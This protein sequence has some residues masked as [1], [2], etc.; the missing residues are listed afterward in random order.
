MQNMDMIGVDVPIESCSIERRKR[1][2]GCGGLHQRY[3][4]SNHFIRK[5]LSF[6]ME[7]INRV[8]LPWE[9]LPSLRW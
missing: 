8:K 3:L 4:R 5:E 6:S 1:R 9:Q 7:R 2:G